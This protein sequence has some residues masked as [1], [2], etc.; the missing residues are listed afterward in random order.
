MIEYSL[1]QKSLKKYIYFL[2]VQ[3][4][5]IVILVGT[6]MIIWYVL[7]KISYKMVNIPLFISWM[8]DEL[9]LRHWKFQLFPWK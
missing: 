6:F 7:Y 9:D 2:V 4:N 1:K 8:K 5:T 3:Y